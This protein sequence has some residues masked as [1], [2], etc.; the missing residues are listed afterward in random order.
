MAKKKIIKKS[1]RMTALQIVKRKGHNE[2]YDERKIY[3]SCYFACRSAHLDEIQS[4][5]ICSKIT[6]AVTKWIIRKKMVSSSDIFKAL[7]NELKKHHEDAAFM[8]ETHWDIS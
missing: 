4:N 2:M 8:Y 7:V 5:N 6:K 1:R 3:A